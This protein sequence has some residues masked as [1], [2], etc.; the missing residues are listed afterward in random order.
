[1]EDPRIGL[2][3]ATARRGHDH[4]EEARQARDGEPRTRHALD[5]VGDDAQPLPLPEL[6]Q[7]GSA[8]GEAVSSPSEVIQVG[9]PQALGRPR[10]GSQLLQQ[11]PEALA[12]EG[13]LGDLPRR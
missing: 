6:E 8:A 3:K 9:F 2:G 13:G 12:S 5:P 7:H 1:M 10:M 4:P 11:L